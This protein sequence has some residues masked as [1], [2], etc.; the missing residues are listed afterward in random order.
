MKNRTPPSV[1]AFVVAV[2]VAF[3]S[4]WLLS[5]V[6]SST[7]RATD[8]LHQSR[9][10]V[11]TYPG[12]PY[13]FAPNPPP[14]LSPDDM[15]LY[16]TDSGALNT[17]TA[18]GS[19][20]TLVPPTASVTSPPVF[21]FPGLVV[22]LGAGSLTSVGCPAT[23]G[24]KY[25]YTATVEFDRIRAAWLNTAVGSENV[26]LS[27]W[28]ADFPLNPPLASVTAVAPSGGSPALITG[29]ISPVT[30]TPGQKL[31]WTA[32]N[33]SDSYC[34]VIAAPSQVLAASYFG[35]SYS[36]TMTN[37]PDAPGEIMLASNLYSS[38]VGSNTFPAATPDPSNFWP[39]RGVRVGEP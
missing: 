23:S 25:V 39:V 37:V 20:T 30:A 1:V 5:T 35:T 18:D 31:I 7:P 27:V 22:A 2:L 13:V 17:I 14:A 15:A 12:A 4:A 38:T 29:A 16:L 33:A 6:G 32:F 8:A 3:G 26:I 10:Q 28:D 19:V 21:D 11:V 24:T 36:M 9:A 34:F